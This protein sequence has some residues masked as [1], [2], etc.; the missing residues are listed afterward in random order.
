[1]RQTST[2]FNVISQNGWRIMNGW[3][4]FWWEFAHAPV[5]W[6]GLYF[7]IIFWL[8]RVSYTALS[9]KRAAKARNSFVCMPV[10]LPVITGLYFMY[11][12]HR[13]QFLAKAEKKMI[14][15][16]VHKRSLL[17]SVCPFVTSRIFEA[18]YPSYFL[19]A[20]KYII[21]HNCKRCW[22]SE[23]FTAAA[24]LK[25]ILSCATSSNLSFKLRPRSLPLTSSPP[26]R[27]KL[28]NRRSGK[29]N[30]SLSVAE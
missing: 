12:A 25:R 9:F 10:H 6:W 8:G 5:Y 4:H 24:K 26:Q 18:I 21:L 19:I 28:L 1:M 15:T 13:V 27:T 14:H 22:G 2:I 16:L 17:A 3:N 23:D 29:R 20:T 7:D 30:S 11:Y